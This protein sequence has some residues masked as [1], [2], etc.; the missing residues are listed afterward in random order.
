MKKLFHRYS[1]KTWIVFGIALV[2]A[3][4]VFPTLPDQIP[5]HFDTSGAPDNYGTR[6]SIFL[7]PGV[8]FGI[9]LLAEFTR[10]YDP[11]SEA[12]ESFQSYYYNIHFAVALLM[13]GA[14]IMIICAIYGIDINM[15]LIMQAG[16]GFLFIFLGNMMPKFKHNYFV[17]IK[18]SWTLASEEVWYLT[19]RFAG[20]VWVVGGLLM[21]L[22]ALLPVEASWWVYLLITLVLA[23]LPLGA[24]FYYYNKLEK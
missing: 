12:Y 13:L 17:G 19:H 4:F 21:L 14:E 20:K 22:S 7:M 8:I 1:R 6:W 5:I 3:V 2:L 15:S 11:R 23:V 10:K 9:Q 24:S 16:A 18:T